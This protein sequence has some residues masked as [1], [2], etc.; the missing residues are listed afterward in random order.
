M[1]DAVQELEEKFD[2]KIPEF[3][4]AAVRIDGEFHH[5]WYLGTEGETS[6]E[7]LK[8]ALDES[9]KNAN[10]NYKVA[11]SKALKGVKVTK[12]HPDIFPEWSAANKKKGGQVKM[13][14]VMDEEKFAKW[15]KFVS[16]KNA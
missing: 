8:E 11:R 13:E 3:T 14:K 16:E 4:L 6:E 1:N 2:I 5:H 9:L 15:E 7:E 12:I 10:K